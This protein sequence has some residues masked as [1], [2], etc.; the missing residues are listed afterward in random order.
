M[1]KLTKE[2][3]LGLI[4]NVEYVVDP[5]VIICKL[6]VGDATVVGTS[7]CF[8]K[9]TFDLERGKQSAYNHA[10]DKLFSLE[11]YHQKR[12]REYFKCPSDVKPSSDYDT[13]SAPGVFCAR[14]ITEPDYTLQVTVD[15]NSDGESKVTKVVLV[16][17]EQQ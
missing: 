4:E 6:K 7:F 10:L 5:Q 8:S 17:H 2:H 15:K 11:A 12:L 9:S 3:V 1:E 16:N 13:I 14:K